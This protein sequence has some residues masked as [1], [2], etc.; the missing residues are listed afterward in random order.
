MV[1]PGRAGRRSIARFGVAHCFDPIV[2]GVPAL[3]PI[4]R[5]SIRSPRLTIALGLIITL[6]VAPGVVRL[7]LRTDGHALVPAYA[8]E[9]EVDREIRA[10]FGVE[11]PLVVLITSS[12]PNGLF[13]IPTLELV[14]D[15]TTEFKQIEG[16]NP[17][18]VF[19]LLTEPSDRVRPGTLHFRTFLEMFPRTPV[20]LDRLRDDLRA[21]E[22]Y[23]GTLVS[24][25]EKSTAIMVGVP[26]DADRIALYRKLKD[27]IADGPDVEDEVHVIGAPVAEALLGTHILEDLGIPSAVLK[28]RTFDA[29]N[30]V[31]WHMPKS[32]H[33]FRVLIARKIGLVPIA[34]LI[35]SLVFLI[36]FR[37]IPAFL[38][39]LMEVGACLAF[40]FGLM[41]WLDVPVYLTVAVLPI[42][43]TAVGVADEIHIFDRY[44]GSLRSR[45]TDP[46][47]GVL[48]AAMQEM[49]TPVV[50]TSLT[51]A[52]GFLSFALSPIRPVQVFG[53]FASV[54]IV[55]CMLW[56]LTV[57]P[58]SL[59]LI[60][61][62]WIAGSRHGTGADRAGGATIMSRLGSAVMRLRF[63]I[64]VLAVGVTLVAPLGVRKILVQDSWIDGFAPESEFHTA[65]S[66][67]NDEFLGTHTLYVRVDTGKVNPLH[68]VV[69]VSSIEHLAVRLPRTI[70][71]NPSDL[72]GNKLYLR[73]PNPPQP[74]PT[75]RRN[76]P[77]EWDTMIDSV[78]VVGD[79]IILNTSR[80][81][82]SPRLAMRFRKLNDVEY[83][84]TPERLLKPEIIRVIQSL[85]SFIDLQKDKAVGGV[86]GTSDYITATNFM[87]RGRKE[88][89]RSIPDRTDRIEWI[90]GQ[91]GRV[92]GAERL[93][94]AVNADYSR[95]LISVY[96]KNANFMDTN[97]L[98]ESSREYEAQPLTPLGFSLEFAGDVAVS[99]TL[100]DAIVSTQVRSLLIS[101][102]GIFAITAIMGRSLVWGVLCVLPCALAVLTNFAVMGWTGMPLGVATSMF[103]GMTLGI[104]V[105]YAI[106]LLE[107]Y[108]MACSHGLPVDQAVADAVA[109]TGPAIVVD[110]LAVALGFGVMTLS[111]VPA[112][113][114]LGGLV[115]LSIGGCFLAT[116]ILLPALLRIFKPGGI[117]HC[118]V[119]KP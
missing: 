60:N 43:L 117:V 48:R 93:A 4:Y 64:L 44:R 40:V 23:T 89:T 30:D 38:L 110:G 41:G 114:R 26:D 1:L 102:L 104:G 5:F 85:E 62:R 32:L 112:N 25:D 113:A 31:A 98:R 111:Q 2:D 27:I 15:L 47:L 7:Q 74:D 84:I 72:P 52:I 34:L 73:N 49:S 19:S 99:Q 77:R 83:E 107:R 8:P 10:E 76:V 20:E 94:Q 59:A 88:G 96:M 51:T 16:V 28:D 9:I 79:E 118:D 109:A 58:A 3:A 36:G 17:W 69:P 101:L 37:S 106:H 100:I 6:A 92:R 68:G 95:S 21:I 11:D 56:S 116:M 63:V 54:G 57:V 35:M 71:K 82:G 75:R 78:E 13:N 91:Y 39:P 22:L 119:L 50:K 80:R 42:V 65:T 24:A 14:C 70:V 18:N 12:H 33:D 108:R 53:L 61:P 55:F 115:V 67:F 81:D 103:A 97:R 46:H 45:P 87:A 66:L 90:W 105:D 86:L 29:D